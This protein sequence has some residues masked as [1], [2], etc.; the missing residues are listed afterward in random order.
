M[1]KSASKAAAKPNKAAPKAQGAEET[2]NPRSRGAQGGKAKNKERTAGR[3]VKPKDG[4]PRQRQFDRRSGTGRG[5]EVA[6]G[7][8]AGWGNSS[9]EA[10]NAEKDGVVDEAAQGHADA[11]IE[12]D[13]DD[14]EGETPKEPEKPTFTYEEFMA[15]K[16]Q[17]RS[18][19]ALFEAK[20]ERKAADVDGM[21]ARGANELGVFMKLGKDKTQREKGVQRSKQKVQAAPGFMLAKPQSDF[22]DRGDRPPRF[23]RR[24]G[25]RREGGRGG[26]DRRGD[27]REGGREGGRGGDRGDRGDRAPRSVP[28]GP[29]MNLADDDAFP[30]L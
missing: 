14:E 15:R 28:R 5:K 8:H 9:T 11:A 25:D 7:G 4:E 10:R 30:K 6:K 24:D 13:G 18:N 20:A 16:N 22:G 23:E 27:R 3:A 12:G 17:E 21:Q 26:G 2:V 19:S 1:Q 29:A